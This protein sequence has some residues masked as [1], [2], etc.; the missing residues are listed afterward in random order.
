M[1]IILAVGLSFCTF[2]Y[3][4]ESSDGTEVSVKEIKKSTPEVVVPV[5]GASPDFMQGLYVTAYTASLK[6]FDNLLEKAKRAGINTIIFDVKEMQGKVYFAIEGD[7]NIKYLHSE[8]LWEIDDVVAKIHAHD[9][10]AVARIV[11]FFNIYTA[12]KH[13]ELQIKTHNGQ[14]WQEKRGKAAWLDPSLPEVQDDLRALIRNIAKSRVDE[15]QLDYMR[16]PTVGNLKEASFY[17]QREDYQKSISDSTYKKR[18]KRHVIA[19]YLESVKKI[20]KENNLRLGGD[21]F[22][23]VAWQRDI[24]IKNTGQDISM[25]TPYLDQLHPMI[26]SSHFARNFSYRRDDFYNKPYSIVREGLLLSKS[27]MKGNCRLIPYLQAFNWKVNYNK[28]Y[29]FDQL[30]AVRDTG[31][32]GY[33]LWNAGNNYDKT[34]DWIREWNSSQSNRM[35]DSS[36]V[37]AGK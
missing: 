19:A 34:I 2:Y 7:R 23:I 17:F 16:F 28:E 27:K 22:A 8:E 33:I 14:I 13:P 1:L 10:I 5:R 4:R 11:Q 21:I 15:I 18:E 32:S 29:L 3:L 31:C 20:C 30:R 12:Q 36:A 37:M 9:M 6:R 35:T 26:Y 25:I 24:D